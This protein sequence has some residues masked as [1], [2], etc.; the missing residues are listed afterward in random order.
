[1][2]PS[3]KPRL[4]ASKIKNIATVLEICSATAKAHS[5]CARMEESKRRL[6]NGEPVYTEC[7]NLEFNQKKHRVQRSQ[8]PES[9]WFCPVAMKRN[10]QTLFLRAKTLRITMSTVMRVRLW[11][12]RSAQ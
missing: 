2:G 4:T 12:A 5:L 8:D 7:W 9:T 10:A 11:A 1:M 3:K 6:T